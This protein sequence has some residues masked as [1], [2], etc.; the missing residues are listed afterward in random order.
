M[1]IITCIKSMVVVALF[2]SI[3]GI[4]LASGSNNFPNRI[5]KQSKAV[6]AAIKAKEINFGESKSLKKEIR[7]I[8]KLY[9]L[10]WKDKSI[11]EKEAKTL[12]TKLNNSDVNLFRKKYD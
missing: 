7:A 10:F 6:E 11:S 1:N 4:A 12:N 8:K 2:M 3:S 5:E 9:K